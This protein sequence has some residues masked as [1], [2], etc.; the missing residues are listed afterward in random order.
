MAIDLTADLFFELQRKISELDKA[1]RDLRVVGEKCAEATN[2]YYDKKNDVAKSL[3]Q[4]KYPV[5]MIQLVVKGEG[6]VPKLLYQKQIAETNYKYCIEKINAIK[7]EIR[8]IEAQ[9][10]REWGSN[11][12][13]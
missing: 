8:L 11:L 10:N 4:L 2:R 9:L 6:E 13:S 12:S 7:L 5:S 1:L 3:H